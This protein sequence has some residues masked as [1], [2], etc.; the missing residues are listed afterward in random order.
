M[1]Q[2]R[3]LAALSRSLSRQVAVFLDRQGRVDLVLVG[4]AGSINIPEL[5]GRR[6]APACAA[7]GSCILTFPGS[8]SPR[9]TSWTFYSCASIA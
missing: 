2:A 1:D 3:E 4:D 9:K 7:C 6:G 5:R 8:P